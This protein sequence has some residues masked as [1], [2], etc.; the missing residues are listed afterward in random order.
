MRMRIYAALAIA[1][2]SHAP[3]S[4]SHEFYGIRY[5][6]PAGSTLASTGNSLPGPEPQEEP[7]RPGEPSKPRPP[8]YIHPGVSVNGLGV[9]IW[10]DPDP[11]TLDAMQASLKQQPQVVRIDEASPRANGWD[12]TYTWRGEDGTQS[13]IF[14]RYY[15]LA[16]EQYSCKYYESYAK[17]AAAEA[18]CR[19]IVKKERP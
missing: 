6:V 2:C 16:G 12:L 5:E 11:T 13:K 19:S 10:K 18:V 3:A 15:Q 4:D 1:A 17:L 7:P 14:T 9:E 8:P